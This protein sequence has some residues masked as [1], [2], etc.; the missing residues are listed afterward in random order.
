MIQKKISEIELDDLQELITNNIAESK[1]LEYKSILKVDKDADKNKSKDEIDEDATEDVNT[2]KT[3]PIDKKESKSDTTEVS[4]KPTPENV[5]E[6]IDENE[7]PKEP[8]KEFTIT[9]NYFATVNY[10]EKMNDGKIEKRNSVLKVKK[11]VQKEDKASEMDKERFQIEVIP[12]SGTSFYVY[13]NAD[14]TVNSVE[15][16]DKK[17]FVRGN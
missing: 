13:L 15:F 5:D 17:M 1:T 2:E 4:D 10:M 14:R 9:T 8:K 16:Q 6:A 7:N 3:E 11:L 12:T